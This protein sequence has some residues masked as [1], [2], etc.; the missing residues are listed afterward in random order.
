MFDGYDRVNLVLSGTAQEQWHVER[1]DTL[2]CD[3]ELACDV[4]AADEYM[5]E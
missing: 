5:H 4:W 2:S 3:G 1:T